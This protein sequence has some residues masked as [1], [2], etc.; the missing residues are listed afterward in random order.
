ML[1]VQQ[2]FAVLKLASLQEPPQSPLV[3][4]GAALKISGSLVS[5][6]ER[7]FEKFANSSISTRKADRVTILRV[8][9]NI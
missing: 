8:N 2:L 6:N 4:I 3:Q 7:N 1:V 9:I 5:K